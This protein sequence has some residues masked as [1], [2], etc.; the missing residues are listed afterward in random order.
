MAGLESD[1]KGLRRVRCPSCPPLASCSQ[2]AEQ[3]AERKI[4][5]IV[6]SWKRIGWD[7]KKR[8]NPGSERALLNRH[9]PTRSAILKFESHQA[10]LPIVHH[11]DSLRTSIVRDVVSTVILK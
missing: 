9:N 6:R 1:A 8:D 11:S 4:E 3:R 7:K 2:D 10:A 5:P